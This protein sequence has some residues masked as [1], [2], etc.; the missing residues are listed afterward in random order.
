M[1][2][3]TDCIRTDGEYAQ[4]LDA[5][6]EG[7]RTKAQP[8]LVSGLCDGAS[9]ALCTALLEDASAFSTQCALFVCADEKDCLRTVELLNRFGHRAAFFPARDLSFYD[10]TASHEYEHER[11]LV[12]SGVL[13][14][15]Y[16]AVVTTPDAALGYTMPVE[17]LREALFTV[18]FNVEI[19]PSALAERLLNLGY[20]R[21]ESVEGIGQFAMRGGIIDIYPPFATFMD[22][23][24]E[25]IHGANPL[26]IE[27][28]GDAVDRMGIFDTDT[29]RI[30]TAV[31]RAT[32]PPAR[33]LIY[34]AEERGRIQRAVRAQYRLCHDAQAK[35][36]LKKEIA[37]IEGDSH[38]ELRFADAYMTLIYP[39]KETLLSYFQKKNL[40]VVRSAA[41]VRDRLKAAEWRM[42]ENIKALLESETVSGKYAEYSLPA[43][44][45]EAFLADRVCVYADALVAGMS[46]KRLSGIFGFRTKHMISY[47]ENF[48]LLCEDLTDLFADG[49]RV[50]VIAENRTAGRHL[51]EMLRDGG[52]VAVT[53]EEG[54]Y[55]RAKDLQSG[56][57]FIVWSQYLYGYELITP[58]VAVLSTNPDAKTG[59]LRQSGYTTRRKK[60]TQDARSIMSWAEL[61]TGDLVVHESYGIGRYTGIEN[62]TSLGVSRDYIGIQFDGTDKLF[63]PVE[64]MDKVSKYI[65]PHADDGT[66]KLSR[67]SGTDWAKAKQRVKTAVRNMAKELIQLYAGRLRQPGYAFPEDDA[68][69]RDFEAAFAYEETQG[70]IDA[71]ADIKADMEKPVPMD[72]LLCGDVG[73]GKTEVALRA[74]FKAVMGGKQVA[75]LVPT[76]L[77]ALQHYQ[78]ALS[79]MRPFAVNV[80][81]ISR[82]RTPKQQTQTL[83]RLARGDL[84]ILIGTHRLLGKDIAFHDLGLLIVDEEQR[85]GV[86][87]KEKLKKMAKNVDVLT[88]SATPIPRTLSMAMGGIRDISLLDEAPGNRLPVQTY[89]LEHDPLVIEDAIRRELRRGGQVF[90]LYNY[91]DTIDRVA[92]KL[93]EQFPD[94]RVTVAHGK[95]DKEQ[96]ESIWEEMLAGNIDIL[97]CTTIIETG[98]DVP[99]ANTLIVENAHRMGLS[100]LHQIR[101]RVGR[102]ARRAYAYFTYPPNQC[103]SEIAEKRLE[104]VREYAEF[105]AGFRIALRDMEI[106]GAGNLLGAEQHGHMDSIGYDLYIRLLND[107]V[108]E[109]QGGKLPEKRECA[110]SIR[111]DANIPAQYVRYPAQRMSLY[112]RIALIRNEYDR[113][114]MTD[115]LLD[116]FGELP[117]PTENLLMIALI[118]ALA[119]ECRLKQIKQEGNEVRMYPEKFDFPVLSSVA[120][121][122]D[123]RIRVVMVGEPHISLR[124]RKGDA[125]LMLLRDVLEK[126][127]QISQKLHEEKT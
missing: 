121:A 91:V 62:V 74:A 96:L 73:Y 5:V 25:E 125:I 101:G 111:V 85:F 52:F 79:R 98:V 18:D 4:L 83:A 81:V 20:A 116:R 60:K 31:S 97:V 1:N 58:R 7:F 107:A 82:F 108:I 36:V 77:L 117:R 33:E 38:A 66:L 90:Y 27:L 57:V 19:E 70:Q 12:L 72:R 75:I 49:H 78:T 26:R 105:G 35:E 87:Q 104:A 110:V 113:L 10:I 28:F 102:S 114:D 34:G 115:E 32:L 42:N 50:I 80:D 68:M 100:Q 119:L 14:D 69:Q 2:I 16:D 53:E 8:I 45:F 44:A 46:G 41:A 122:F 103:V 76:T 55:Y 118:R 3:L 47:A 95:M 59:S 54:R 21:V 93:A 37:T 88:L 24:G 13:L 99:N 61:Q 22:T 126:Y 84:D 17:R 67:L 63:L 56:T 94:A 109:E 43:G 40:T 124:L 30:R 64:Q 29:Q 112:K 39:E 51:R 123:G 65:G 127:T 86:A 15:S 6:R 106:R 89:V 71:I 23:D 9:D 11:L 48:K 92:A 120:A